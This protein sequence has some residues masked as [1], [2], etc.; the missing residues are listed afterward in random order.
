MLMIFSARRGRNYRVRAHLWG[1]AAPTPAGVGDPRD[2]AWG[3][4]V[5]LMAGAA[6]TGILAA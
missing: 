6:T 1:M 4:V 2:T 3:S 5:L